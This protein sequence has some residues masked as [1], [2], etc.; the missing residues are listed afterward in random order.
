MDMDTSSPMRG[1]DATPPAA[2]TP[3]AVIS[4]STSAAQPSQHSPAGM[5]HHHL[6]SLALHETGED[7]EPDRLT[8]L[9]LPILLTILARL[10]PLQRSAAACCSTRLNAASTHPDGACVSRP[11]IM[12]DTCPQSLTHWSHSTAWLHLDLGAF[13]GRCLTDALLMRCVS[14]AVDATTG[15]NKL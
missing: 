13:P 3:P 14:R 7:E 6:A 15:A 2:D 4:T 8:G 1:L 5:H 10:P 12:R 9:P 11:D